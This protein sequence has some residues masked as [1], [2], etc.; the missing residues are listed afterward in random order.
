MKILIRKE[1]KKFI[2]Q[3]F[4]HRLPR[5]I[6]TLIIHTQIIESVLFMFQQFLQVESKAQQHAFNLTCYT[7]IVSL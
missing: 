2:L 7:T 6:H 5:I 3:N 4:L 1:K